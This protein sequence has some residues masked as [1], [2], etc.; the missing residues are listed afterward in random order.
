M[1]DRLSA[2][3]VACDLVQRPEKLLTDGQAAATGIHLT[4]PVEGFGTL[5]F[6]GIPLCFDGIRPQ[7]RMPSDR[8]WTSAD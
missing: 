4:V 5:R 7:V 1:V 8:R 6:P 2:H 3:G